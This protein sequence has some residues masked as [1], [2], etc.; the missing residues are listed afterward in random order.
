MR[1]PIRAV[2][3][4]VALVLVLLSLVLFSAGVAPPELVAL[5]SWDGLPTVAPASPMAERLTVLDMAVL[6][7]MTLLTFATYRYRRRLLALRLTSLAF[8][9]RST[10]WRLTAALTGVRRTAIRTLFTARSAT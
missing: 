4:L 3:T 5:P 8:E 7:F 10:T 9:I 6:A 2:V 1:N